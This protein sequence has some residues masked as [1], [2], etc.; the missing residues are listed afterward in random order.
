VTKY[1]LEDFDV[2]YRESQKRYFVIL[3]KTRG[4]N[5][6]YLTTDGR[7]S[8]TASFGWFDD[9]TQV[10]RSIDLLNNAE[11][12]ISINDAL[13]I[14]KAHYDKPVIGLDLKDISYLNMS[15]GD[16]LRSL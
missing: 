7:L 11:F 4:V 1:K 9:H 10:R 8:N 15:L 13:V 6:T 12:C 3:R 14:L 5:D 16:I 2:E